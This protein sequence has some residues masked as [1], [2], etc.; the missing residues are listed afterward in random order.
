MKAALAAAGCLCRY[1]TETALSTCV[2]LFL[3]ILQH[4]SGSDPWCKFNDHMLQ[5]FTSCLFLAGGVA[6]I[7]GSWTCKRWVGTAGACAGRVAGWL[8]GW[9]AGL[10]HSSQPQESTRTAELLAKTSSPT[11]MRWRLCLLLH[12]YRY[13]R[14][15]TMMAGGACFLTGTVLVTL[16]VHMV[17]LVLGR[18]VLGIGVGFATQV[19]C[20]TVAV[21][22]CVW[23]RQAASR[24]RWCV[25]HGRTVAVVLCGGVRQQMVR[26]CPAWFAG[27]SW[28]PQCSLA[29]SFL[30]GLGRY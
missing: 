15:A 4:S 29:P 7:V 20:R 8:A 5:L 14:K 19:R 12:V 24:W 17:M 1:C 25:L 30:H 16:A 6:A 23:K 21:V 11:A 18:I 10:P 3:S 9:H 27:E 2:F 28:P 26:V 22:P 13:G